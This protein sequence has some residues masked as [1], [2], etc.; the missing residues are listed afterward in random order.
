[1]PTPPQLP[2]WPLRRLSWS[3]PSNIPLQTLFTRSRQA[4]GSAPTSFIFSREGWREG[5]LFYWLDGLLSHVIWS[6]NTHHVTAI[7]DFARIT[8][9]IK[10]CWNLMFVI[11]GIF[12]SFKSRHVWTDR[13]TLVHYLQKPDESGC[14]A[15]A[16]KY[17]TV[18]TLEVWI[19]ISD[20]PIHSPQ[21]IS[22]LTSSVFYIAPH[23][24]ILTT[25]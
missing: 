13:D 16:M 9:I 19:F 2:C 21:S 24:C 3:S 18:Y 14:S 20:S 4:E 8:A 22:Y 17:Y 1:M 5:W 6:S 15:N 12:E 11:N 25:S 7:Y 23:S 10:H